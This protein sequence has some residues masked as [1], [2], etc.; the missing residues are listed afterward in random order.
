MK[1]IRRLGT[2]L[3][4]AVLCA[5]VL[6]VPALADGEDVTISLSQT[7]IYLPVGQSQKVT[8]TASDGKAVTWVSLTSGVASVDSAGNITALAEGSATVQAKS[9][10]GSAVANCKVIAYM[11]FPSYALRV[12]ESMSL[13][14]SFSGTW[15]SADESVATVS[16]S[17][18]VTGQGFGRTYITVRSGS[19]CESFSITV[20]GHVGIDISSWNNTID[21]DALKEQ[22]I[23]FVMIRVGYGENSTDKRFVENIE[24]AIRSGMPFGVYYYS[25]AKDTAKA[26]REA[27]YCLKQLEPY[28]DKLTLPVAY[29]LEEY[30]DLTGEQ[31]VEIAE[32]FC[33][34]VQDAGLNA[35]VY[36]NGNFYS[37]MD[38]S[39]LTDMGVDYWYAWYPTV[40]DLSTIHTI[41]G[42]S[43]KPNIWQYSSSCV[44]QGALASGKTD[45]NVL[46]MPEYLSFSAP[47]LE[48]E[49]SS[50][51]AR[52]RWGGSSYA[53][54]YTVYK[55]TASGEVSKVGTYD[56]NVHSCTDQSYLPGEGYYVT[57]EISDPIDGTYYKSYTS[58]TVYPETARYEVRVSAQE[59]GSA[60]GGGS[61]LV[62]KTVTVKAAADEGYTFTGWYNAA[63][64]KVSSSAEYSFTVTA[65]VA[66]TARFEPKQTEVG[67]GFT[68]VKST[69]WYAEAVAYVVDNG[70]FTGTSDTTFTPGGTMTR[71]MLV[72]VLY[73][74]A[75]SPEVS[76]HNKFIDVSAAAWYAKAVTWGYNNGVV[77]GTG[78]KTFSPEEPV[79]R[80]QMAA[81]LMRYSDKMGMDVPATTDGNLSAFSD[82][83][84]IAPYF[85][86]GMRWAVSAQLL[87]GA[88][89]KLMPR[90]SASRAECA[91]IL[92][93]WMESVQ[94]Q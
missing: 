78:E 75:G 60:S 57:M 45:I 14:A 40:P 20:G 46:Y 85:E 5:S 94:E 88:D 43:S 72:T 7:T 35:M 79:T 59:G 17:G 41:R 73:R 27:A 21:W 49:A 42:T 93:R 84:E 80:E 76:N 31:L 38:L 53:S 18:T 52:L 28:M 48:A 29:D 32:T 65:S 37:K 2:A 68:D 26:S 67:T 9:A 55:Q 74:Q 1:I 63:G 16:S 61:F 91:A 56:G 23:E 71:G 66:L 11:A 54:S 33:T 64:S 39:S 47:V 22:G 25:Y 87:N 50:S 4:A 6:C 34:A 30:S 82:T 36:A 81:I 12:G 92:M 89:G 10:D 69:D 3:L 8:A 15:T 13:D 70:L 86:D 19:R 44:V 77:N 83:S 51:A 58:Q 24:G 62:G 90:K